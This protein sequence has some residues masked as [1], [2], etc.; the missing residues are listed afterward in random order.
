MF[1]RKVI[2]KKN[3]VI[4]EYDKPFLIAE[5][6]INHNGSLALAKKTILK[7]KK[8]GA[9][10]VKIQT[11]KTESFC[12]NSSKYYSLFKSV[13]LNAKQ[14][15]SLYKFAKQNNIL[16]FSSV[17]DEWSTDLNYKNKAQL[18]KIASG[19]ITNLPLIE[20]ASK[21]KLPIIIST[22]GSTIKEIEEAVK[23]VY[24]IN[25][26]IKIALLHCVSKYPAKADECNLKSML[27]IKEKFKLPVGF[28]DHTIGIETS[29]SA[30]ALGAEIIEKH[31]TLDKN[32]PGPDH[33]LSS[34]PDEFKKLSLVIKTAYLSIGNKKKK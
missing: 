29:I 3:K 22:G 6:G 27:I 12:Q 2:I 8:S 33:K 31:F 34:D 16:L 1:I 15:S 30:V 11:F 13:E 23:T 5:V 10:A 32:L 19:D 21:K 17:F 20:Y 14:V 24:L 18:L 28:S 4:F 25:K 26:K 9:S 7:A